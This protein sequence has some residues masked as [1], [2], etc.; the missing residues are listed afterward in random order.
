MHELV[1][2]KNLIPPLLAT[3][4]PYSV[5]DAMV[6]CWCHVGNT[7]GPYLIFINAKA[8]YP[9]WDWILYLYP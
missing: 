8:T 6:V 4:Y 5:Q 1:K 3:V 2:V 9:Q 7:V